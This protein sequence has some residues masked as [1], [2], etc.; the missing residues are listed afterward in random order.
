MKQVSR[1]VTLTLINIQI[2]VLCPVQRAVGELMCEK[3]RHALCRLVSDRQHVNI[4]E[5]EMSCDVF[6]AEAVDLV[7][8]SL[9]RRPVDVLRSVLGEQG[10]EEEE[11]NRS[12]TRHRMMRKGEVNQVNGQ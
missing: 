9:P 12:N 7:V 8:A 3:R 6:D 5:R 4:P 11:G 1:K 2:L 10:D